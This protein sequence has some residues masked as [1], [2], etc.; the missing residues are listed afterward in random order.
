MRAYP[1]YLGVS[2]AGA[3]AGT[4]AFTLNLV[5]QVETVGLGPLQLLLVGTVME[6]VAFLAQVPTGIIADLYSRRL[7][8]IVGHLLMGAGVLVWGLVPQFWAIL[9]ANAVWGIGAVC[10]EGAQ[11]AWLADELGEDDVGPAFARGGQVGQ[12]A[13][14]A[15]ILAAVGLATVDLALPIVVGGAVSFLL[16]LALIGLMR[17]HNFHPAVAI[18]PSGTIRSAG[19]FRA[20]RDQAVAGSR[21]VRARPALVLLF[22]A[23]FFVAFSSEGID[24]LS[25]PHLLTFPMPGSPLVWFGA[26][27][28]GGLL[29][30]MAVGEVIRRRIADL[31]PARL[32]AVLAGIQAIQVA[33]IVAFA[34][35]GQFWLAAVASLVA[36]ASRGVF[37]PLFGTWVVARTQSA[38][39]ATVFSMAGQV[40]A[41][42]QIVGGPPIGYVG[43]RLTI[44]AALVATGLVLVPAVWLVGAARRREARE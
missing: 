16:G 29:A 14:I 24:R 4:V 9:L 15:G 44:R 13:T 3:F 32:G 39:R 43:E 26:L 1:L 20:M 23:L 10:V 21:A 6:A 36:G 25:Q 30:A 28:I 19:S 35:A 7:S 27:A 33:A 2:A 11:E 12:A 41:A 5:Y 22:A 40:D 18:S 37:G 31:P 38:T 17:E 42:G 34:L 8:I